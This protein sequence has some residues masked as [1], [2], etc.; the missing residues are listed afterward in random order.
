MRVARVCAAHPALAEAVCSGALPLGRADTLARVVTAER[1]PFLA[2]SLPALLRLGTTTAEDDRFATAVRYWADRVDEQLAPDQGP[3]HRRYLTPRLFGGG[4]VDGE[5]TPASFATVAAALDAYTQDPDPSDAPYRRTL[6]ERRA[7]ALDDLADFGLSH[8]CDDECGDDLTDRAEDTFD[9]V[10]GRDELDEQLEALDTGQEIDPLDA[11][12]RRLRRA[13]RRRRRR[14]RRRT[15][16]RSGVRV[17]VHIDL[18]TLAG[19]RSLDDPDLFDGLV[20]RGEHWRLAE[21]SARRLLCDSALVAT[22]FD[23]QR[24]LD[25]NGVRR[26]VQPAAAARAGRPRRALRVPWLSTPTPALPRP[27]PRVPGPRRAHDRCERLSGV[28]LPPPVDPR[29][30]LVTPTG[31]R[32]HLDGHRSTR[33]LVDDAKTRAG[34]RRHRLIARVRTQD[35]ARVRTNRPGA[36]RGRAPGHRRAQLSSRHASARTVACRWKVCTATRRT[37]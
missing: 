22:L 4:R 12:R 3:D 36:H 16:A 31:R 25:A 1:A 28:R 21:N 24:V 29:A 19:D 11:I 23:G 13:E 33:Q 35:P 10:D 18:R 6:A 32:R 20:L 5:L 8:G 34:F 27:P 14:M 2:D 26:A 9:G 15:K 17:D 30:R 37:T 7:D